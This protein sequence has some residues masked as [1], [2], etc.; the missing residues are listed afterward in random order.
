MMSMAAPDGLTIWEAQFG[1]FSNEHKFY[2]SVFI[3]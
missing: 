1:D 3:R 2:R